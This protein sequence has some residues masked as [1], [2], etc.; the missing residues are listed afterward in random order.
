M[1]VFQLIKYPTAEMQALH[2][3]AVIATGLDESVSVT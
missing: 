2:R 1:P 3:L